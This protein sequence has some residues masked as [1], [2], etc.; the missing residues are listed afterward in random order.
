[1]KT[2]FRL[3]FAAVALAAVAVI[4]GDRLAPPKSMLGLLALAGFL[5]G[6]DLLAWQHMTQLGCG[7]QPMARQPGTQQGQRVAYVMLDLDRRG[8]D[9]R[10]FVAALERWIIGALAAFNVRGETREDRVGV[11]VRRPDKGNGAEDKIAAI[12][13]RAHE[14]G[15]A[16][17]PGDF[18]KLK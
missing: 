8:K 5:F 14:I 3:A 7:L 1:M 4:R 13:I 10:A 9:V 12:G 11:W 16:L 17:D 6:A 15:V 18:L 2:S